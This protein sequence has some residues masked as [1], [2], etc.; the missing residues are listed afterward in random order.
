MKYSVVLPCKDEEKTI[1]ICIKKIQKAL[2]EA[3]I[4]VVDNNSKDTSSSIAGKL[5]ARVV[6][7]ER[8]GYGAALLR[9]FK[10]AKGECVIMGDADDTYDFLELPKLVKHADKYDIVIGN[11]LNGKMK[12]NAMPFLH[13]YIGN[14]GLSWM[15]RKFFKVN[16]RDA[17]SGFRAIKKKSFEKL[18]L[19]T[20]GMDFVSEMIIRASKQ[21]MKI[22]EVPITYHPRKGE[23]KLSTFKDGWKYL[24]LMLLY[25]PSHLFLVPGISLFVLG[26]LIIGFLM[27][28]PLR[29]NGVTLE[30][31]PV[32]I[33]SL[34][35]ITGYQ[36]IMLWLYSKAYS[37]THLGERDKSMDFVNKH[38]T[39]EKSIMLGITILLAGL[40]LN[41][42]ILTKWVQAGFGELEEIKTGVLGL[43]LI[44][45]GVQ[46]IFSG[47]YVSMTGMKQ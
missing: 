44:V 32:F 22:K 4:I 33:G 6:R 9:G 36:V 12:K 25:S 38:F 35:T 27:T 46:T 15:L 31:H 24:R 37:T 41:A 39:L 13:R 10:E 3:E 2:P 8:Q 16:V 42:Y 1:G 26:I 18:S 20:K 17:H 14:P 19:K 40:A 7:E 34:L 11:R 29:L 21:D 43:T 5:G 47:F 28:G 30:T 45:I 23:S